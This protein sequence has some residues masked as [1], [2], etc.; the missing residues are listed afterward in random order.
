[1]ARIAGVEIPDGKQAEVALTYIHGI[2]RTSA[3]KILAKAGVEKSRK[4]GKLTEPELARIRGIIEREYKVEGEL[5]QMVQEHI[6]R[7]IDIKA[8]RGTRRLAGLPVRGQRT[9]KNARSWKGPRPS[10]LRKKRPAAT[11]AA[12]GG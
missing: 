3:L 1:M 10:I 11:G 5:R 7:L 9:R 12:T 8:Y 4:I 6:K 2:G